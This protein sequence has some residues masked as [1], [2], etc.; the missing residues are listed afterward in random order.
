MLK[1]VGVCF[2]TTFCLH[3]DLETNLLNFMCS[4]VLH[5]C[6]YVYHIHGW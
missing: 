3:Y 4:V 2:L 6:M 5:A 1:S